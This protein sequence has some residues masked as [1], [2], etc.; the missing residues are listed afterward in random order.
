MKRFLKKII[1]FCL[2]FFSFA[3]VSF[4]TYLN[5]NK[6]S[7]PVLMYHYVGE[8]DH[9]LN[10]RLFIKPEVFERQMR[11]LKEHNYNVISLGEYVK[12]LKDRAPLPRN[13]VVLTFDD[14]HRSLFKYVFGILKKYQLPAT[15]FVIVSKLDKEG[16][17][18]SEE[19]RKLSESELITIG[20][21]TISHLH[22]PSITDKQRLR[23]EIIDSKIM[24]E[25]IINK[26][27]DYFSYPIGGF[28]E[29]IRKIVI[30]A[31]YA[32]A[33]ATSPGWDYPNNYPYAIKRIRISNNSNNLLIFYI[34]LSG[35]YKPILE[36]R[37]KYFHE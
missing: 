22:L 12:A 8:P 34:E 26:K 25:R 18:T 27:V 5:A 20:S 29:E 9:I 33:V 19:L 35:L 16:W 14:G 11:F 10:H 7:V 31:G 28:N 24:L 17:L 3:T 15:F 2:L 32:G 4:F 1:L 37:K 36:L 23:S 30:E 13:T 21:H 6:Y